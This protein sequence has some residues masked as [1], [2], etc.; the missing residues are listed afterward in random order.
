MI[1]FS[2]LIVKHPS[3]ADTGNAPKS[4]TYR[5]GD[6][7]KN[8]NKKLHTKRKHHKQ[9]PKSFKGYEARKENKMSRIT[10]NGKLIDS[11]KKLLSDLGYDSQ[12]MTVED[13]EEIENNGWLTYCEGR[14]GLE[15]LYY[16][17]SDGLESYLEIETEEILVKR[18]GINMSKQEL[19]EEN[20]RLKEAL[21]NIIKDAHLELN[22]ED[23]TEM[24]YYLN[25]K[26]GLMA[27][28]L[29]NIGE[30]AKNALNIKGRWYELC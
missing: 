17:D 3:K 14:D 4:K 24:T 2:V 23:K 6:D 28:R 1:S 30:K 10:D 13:I 18:N 9:N 12:S 26:S 29:S 20:N 22:P 15:Y 25:D 7:K 16:L 27:Y 19:M 8:Q 11:A 5:K 21:E